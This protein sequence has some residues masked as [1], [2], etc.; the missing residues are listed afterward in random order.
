M[1]PD[2]MTVIFHD[3]G[4][5]TIVQGDDGE[6]LYADGEWPCQVY[7]ACGCCGII[8][9]PVPRSQRTGTRPWGS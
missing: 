5:A 7:L 2:S 1:G 4:T 6:P 9:C 8:D 3:D